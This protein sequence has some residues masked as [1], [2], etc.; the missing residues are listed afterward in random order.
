MKNNNCVVSLPPSL[1]MRMCL[2]LP[3][4]PSSQSYGAFMTQSPKGPTSSHYCTGVTFQPEFQ[5]NANFPSTAVVG[6]LDVWRC[7]CPSL[8][9]V[10]HCVQLFFQAVCFM[11]STCFP[12]RFWHFGVLGDFVHHQPLIKSPGSLRL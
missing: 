10:A 5:R 6:N 12:S 9:R 4:R 7:S 2:S 1:F 8:V 11:L 3:F